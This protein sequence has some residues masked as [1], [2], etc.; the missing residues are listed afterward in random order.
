VKKSR[1]PSALKSVSPGLTC[2]NFIAVLFSMED[3]LDDR[4][5]NGIKHGLFQADASMT[6][7]FICAA[8]HHEGASALNWRAI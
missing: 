6:M 3:L 2:E 7:P 5:D 1:R 8:T 4:R